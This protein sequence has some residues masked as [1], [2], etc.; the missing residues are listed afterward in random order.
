MNTANNITSNAQAEAFVGVNY[1]YYQAK[2]QKIADNKNNPMTWNWAA[3]FLGVVWLVYR[4]M[5][6]YALIFIGLIVLDI[7]IESFFPLPEVFSNA[8]NLMI[9]LG[10]GFY[11]NALY[12]M[13]MNKKVSE[14]VQTYPPAQLEAELTAQG[15][16]NL[17][18]A[19][20]LGVFLV[21]L[22]GVAVWAVLTVGV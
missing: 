3:F 4:K 14:I 19:W 16:V 15:G 21:V 20:T 22:V 11:G 9:A 7:M 10:F 6:H 12:Q 13:H 18:G 17:A 2:W 5:Y 1:S 8:V